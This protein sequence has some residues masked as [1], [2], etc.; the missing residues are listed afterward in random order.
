[1]VRRGRHMRFLTLFLALALSAAAAAGPVQAEDGET[2]SPAP[3]ISY[4][5]E[6][7]DLGG[8][9]VVLGE[10][11]GEKPAVWMWLYRGSEDNYFANEASCTTL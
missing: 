11:F 5:V 10:N 2:G 6:G 8:T 7:T 1:M 9:L 4:V 3:E